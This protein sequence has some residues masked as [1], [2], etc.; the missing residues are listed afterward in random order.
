MALYL[1]FTYQ[2]NIHS[3]EPETEEAEKAQDDHMRIAVS[4]VQGT[5][6][7][8]RKLAEEGKLGARNKE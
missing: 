8:L 7:A 5:I 3:I 1:I 2:W 6:R 4:S